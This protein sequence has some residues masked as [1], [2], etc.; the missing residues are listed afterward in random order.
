MQFPEFGSRCFKN[1]ANDPRIVIVRWAKNGKNHWSVSHS[2][3]PDH[4]NFGDTYLCRTDCFRLC[5]SPG[6]CRYADSSFALFARLVRSGPELA[7]FRVK[8]KTSL[9]KGC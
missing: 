8:Q 4:H 3:S 2:S 6:Y 9:Q 5:S 7:N 1:T